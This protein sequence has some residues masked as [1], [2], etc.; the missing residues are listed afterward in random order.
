MKSNKRK[1]EIR[2]QSNKKSDTS[3]KNSIYKTNKV[4][5]YYKDNSKQNII[6][7]KQKEKYIAVL[8][9]GIVKELMQQKIITRNEME[10]IIK[11]IKKQD[12]LEVEIE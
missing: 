8:K 7:N 1:N 6:S 3:L 2:N 5:Y 9:I 10:I 12:K 11:Q 4:S